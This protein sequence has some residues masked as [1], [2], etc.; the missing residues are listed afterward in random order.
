M[1]QSLHCRIELPTTGLLIN[2]LTYLLTS[3]SKGLHRLL[4]G[5]SLSALTDGSD[6]VMAR[7]GDVTDDDN[8]MSLLLLRLMI[9]VKRSSTELQGDVLT[10]E[11][12]PSAS[13]SWRWRRNSESV[14][15]SIR[16]LSTHYLL[17]EFLL[18]FVNEK[19][20]SF[21]CRALFAVNGCETTRQTPIET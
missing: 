12:S 5:M 13:Y 17:R 10:T 6:G 18:L 14:T 9:A 7:C 11:Q 21:A 20:N 15:I 1:Y 2:L 19:I 3:T 4:S 8:V 16:R